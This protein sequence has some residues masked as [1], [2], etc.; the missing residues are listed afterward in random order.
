L[1]GQTKLKRLGN[2]DLVNDIASSLLK[3]K[4]DEKGPEKVIRV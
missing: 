1:E 2:E 4:H 3:N